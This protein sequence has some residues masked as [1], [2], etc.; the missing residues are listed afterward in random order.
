MSSTSLPAA[1]VE[2]G[3]EDFVPGTLSGLCRAPCTLT[4]EGAQGGGG[5]FSDG[6]AQCS[7]AGVVL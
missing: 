6:G 7:E 4:G 2:G 3:G 1:V 5:C